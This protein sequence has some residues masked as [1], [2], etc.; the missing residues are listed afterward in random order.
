MSTSPPVGT[1][2]LHRRLALQEEVQPIGRLSLGGELLGGLEFLDV[3]DVAHQLQIDVVQFGEDA[4]LT[5]LAGFAL[6]SDLSAASSDG[7]AEA[8]RHHLADALR[9]LVADVLVRL[10]ELTE[11]APDT[12]IAS[13]GSVVQAEAV[14]TCGSITA[15]QP[16]SSPG[17]SSSM[18]TC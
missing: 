18:G 15:P 13:D 16:S 8:P 5:Q 12:T 7:L 14:K 1:A 2:Y 4:E 10:A 6:F 11:L 3:G 9:H 17:P